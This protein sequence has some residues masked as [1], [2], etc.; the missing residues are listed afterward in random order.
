MHLSWVW[1]ARHNTCLLVDG[2]QICQIDSST[3]VKSKN[4]FFAF[5]AIGFNQREISTPDLKVITVSAAYQ[6]NIRN[7]HKFSAGLDLFFDENYFQ[8]MIFSQ[9]SLRP[10]N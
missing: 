2:K 4:E 1:V 9:L 10:Q 3:A 6:R 7:T 5:A 8:K